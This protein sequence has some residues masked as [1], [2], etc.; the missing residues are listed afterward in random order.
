MGNEDNKGKRG[1]RE[2]MGNKVN[3]GYISNKGNQGNN[4][5]Y[6]RIMSTEERR[7]LYDVV[8]QNKGPVQVY[9]YSTKINDCVVMALSYVIMEGFFWT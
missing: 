9:V 6:Q 4:K 8:L 2:N 7:I 3:R 5:L 1:N